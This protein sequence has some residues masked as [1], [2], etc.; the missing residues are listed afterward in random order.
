MPPSRMAPKDS[1]KSRLVEV[2]R[3]LLGGIRGFRDAAAAPIYKVCA[4]N[5]SELHSLVS[6]KIELKRGNSVAYRKLLTIKTQPISKMSDIS[7][8]TK[9]RAE[10]SQSLCQTG[11]ESE[12]VNLIEPIGMICDQT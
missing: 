1:S 11:P 9:F 6:L 10:H 2:H 12:A 7:A 4:L 3:T 5:A 8:M